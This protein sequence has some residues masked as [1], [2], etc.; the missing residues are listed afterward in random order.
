SVV[1]AATASPYFNPLPLP[2]A[3][4]IFG[5]LDALHR[6]LRGIFDPDFPGAV[7]QY[8]GHGVARQPFAER[9]EIGVEI[10]AA[11]RRGGR[12]VRLVRSE[13]HTS[14]LQSREKHVCRL[15]LEK[16]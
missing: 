6:G 4:P 8:L 5:R 10:D 2:D 14:E 7:D 15:L 9:G 11:A 1:L 3:L 12:C 13:E 16:K